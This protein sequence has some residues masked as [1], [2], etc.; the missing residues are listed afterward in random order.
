[1]CRKTGAR[2]MAHAVREPLLER[3]TLSGEF[4]APLMAAAVCD[5]DPS[6]CWW[7]I[8]PALYAFGHWRASIGVMTCRWT[9]PWL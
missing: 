9:A 8:E 3:V 7:F 2:H 4:F 1:M 5:P 6:F